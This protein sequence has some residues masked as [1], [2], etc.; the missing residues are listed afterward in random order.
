[1]A[2]MAG[3]KCRVWVETPNGEVMEVA[4]FCAEI[5]VSMSYEGLVQTHLEFD[6]FDSAIWTDRESFHA[7]LSARKDAPEWKCGYC[8]RPN[9][10][11]D[12][13]CKSCGAVRSFIYA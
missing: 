12:E 10:K 9:Q 2:V 13:T 8:G 4:A 11:H 5:S 6:S 3:N 1:M 7:K